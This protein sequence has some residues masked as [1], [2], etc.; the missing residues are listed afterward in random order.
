MVVAVLLDDP[1]RA[2]WDVE[3]HLAVSPRWNQRLPPPAVK[4][5]SPGPHPSQRLAVS[6]HVEPGVSTRSVT[7]PW[8]RAVSRFFLLAVSPFRDVLLV[9]QGS[10]L[11]AGPI[12]LSQNVSVI[13]II[14]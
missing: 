3:P 11:A 7:G 13:T 12:L 9:A 5:H 8:L 4:H 2:A 14:R 1:R 10:S 6:D